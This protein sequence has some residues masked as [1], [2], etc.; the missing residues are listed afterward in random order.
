LEKAKRCWP[1]RFSFFSFIRAFFAQGGGKKRKKKGV[2]VRT[3]LR[4]NKTLLPPL[5]SPLHCLG[6]FGERRKGCS[7]SPKLCGK[8][9]I[10]RRR[11]EEREGKERKKGKG[12]WPSNSAGVLAML[13]LTEGEKRQH[14]EGG[15]E[16]EEKKKEGKGW[17]RVPDVHM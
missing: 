2:G 10:S 14:R 8:P 13:F 3:G 5:S 16:E 11:R 12:K 17:V 6:G 4:S 1:T 9:V 15:G 7:V